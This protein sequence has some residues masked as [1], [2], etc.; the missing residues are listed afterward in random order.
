MID[1]MP[2][3]IA[4]TTGSL[5]LLEFATI[6]K[7]VLEIALRVSETDKTVLFPEASALPLLYCFK[8]FQDNIP[9]LQNLKDKLIFS[10][11]I[12]A[13]TKS[14]LSKQICGLLSE[15]ER[16][17]LLTDKQKVLFADATKKLSPDIQ[18]LINQ[19]LSGRDISQITLSE[20]ALLVADTGVYIPTEDKKRWEEFGVLSAGQTLDFNAD[21]ASFVND[22]H[23]FRNK[24]ISAIVH[25]IDKIEHKTRPLLNI[26]LSNTAF[27]RALQ[28]GDV[29]IIDEAISRGRTLN[30]IEL[31]IKS[32]YLSGKWKIGVLF[33][34]DFSKRIGNIDCVLSSLKASP[35]SNRLD[36]IGEIIVESDISFNRY[37]IFNFKPTVITKSDRTDLASLE[38]HLESLIT[39]KL[40]NLSNISEG[41]VSV[42]DIKRLIVLYFVGGEIMVKKGLDLNP[43]DGPGLVEEVDFYINMPH[44]FLPID[45]RN[46][47]KNSMLLLLDAIV[48]SEDQAFRKDL[49]I[50]QNKFIAAKEAYEAEKILIWQKSHKK[51]YNEM[52]R[53]LTKLSEDYE[54]K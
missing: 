29:Y 10:S 42:D 9:K 14:P 45:Q 11:K 43:I 33:S 44:P 30:A 27:S 51:A 15:I 24:A 4:R 35:F 37:N 53:A 48:K 2:N 13:T 21:N 50:L 20:L 47:Y 12:T 23:L 1:K 52:D 54:E 7:K 8:Y 34:P 16:K 18:I 39:D 40:L 17:S 41:I 22:F 6:P 36:L 38:K 19:S 26:I 5:A 46:R 3:K 31:I 32:F 49:K 28:D 25:S